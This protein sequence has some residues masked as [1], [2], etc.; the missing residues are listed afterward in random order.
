VWLGEGAGGW[1]E[2]GRWRKNVI[3][4]PGEGRERG[5]TFPLN[6]KEGR[7]VTNAENDG[8]EKGREQRGKGYRKKNSSSFGGKK[9]TGSARDQTSGRT[10][11]A[12]RNARPAA[13][14]EESGRVRG[15][16]R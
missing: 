9:D 12:G 15:S 11:G 5:G 2:V 10:S 3:R 1:K 8:D 4:C 13:G 14:G 16:Q 7:K 6:G